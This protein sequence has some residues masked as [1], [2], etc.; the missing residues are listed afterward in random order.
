MKKCRFAAEDEI[1]SPFKVKAPA[2][3]AYVNTYWPTPGVASCEAVVLS[4]R[5]AVAEV[6]AVVSQAAPPR[7][8]R[9]GGNAAHFVLYPT[10][11]VPMVRIAVPALASTAVVRA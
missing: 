5:Q 6:G 10:S 8:L 3:V 1:G 11:P 2:F 7:S 4:M 9:L